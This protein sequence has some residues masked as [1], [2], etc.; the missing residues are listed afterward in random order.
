MKKFSIMDD[1]NKGADAA[2]AEAGGGDGATMGGSPLSVDV[3]CVPRS[4]SAVCVKL[5]VR[6]VTVS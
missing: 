1:P 3:E 6:A 4:S 2:E 5:T